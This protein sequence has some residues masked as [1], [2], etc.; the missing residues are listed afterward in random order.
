MTPL[1]EY[2]TKYR[3]FNQ[4]QDIIGRTALS[5]AVLNS[6]QEIIRTLLESG[7]DV[8]V[9]DIVGSTPLFYAVKNENKEAVRKLIAAGAFVNVTSKT[10]ET[11]LSLASSLE[12]NEIIL[13]LIHDGLSTQEKEDLL[14][15]ATEEGF[16]SIESY[17]TQSSKK[18]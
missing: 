18:D 3:A 6:S 1:F 13:L 12:S 2:R 4:A 9:T 16:D 11:P 7:A 5:Y 8:N 17:L 15:L 14:K 10:K